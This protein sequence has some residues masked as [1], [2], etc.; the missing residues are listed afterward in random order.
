MTL[1]VAIIGLGTLAG[2]LFNIIMN[3]RVIYKVIGIVIT[4]ATGTFSCCVVLFPYNF[5]DSYT[6]LIIKLSLSAVLLVVIYISAR[7]IVNAVST[8][9][10]GKDTK[11]DKDKLKAEPVAE[12][13]SVA[14]F[15][16][17]NRVKDIITADKTVRSPAQKVS[18]NL[19]NY[20]PK[21]AAVKAT[22]EETHSAQSAAKQT[23]GQA[24]KDADEKILSQSKSLTESVG[25]AVKTG[26]DKPAD[27]ELVSAA[28][29][30][31]DDAKPAPGAMYEQSEQKVGADV[32]AGAETRASEP[33]LEKP[34]GS[35]VSETK[36]EA[37]GAEALDALI[38]KFVKDK[39]ADAELVSAAVLKSNDA[40]PALGAMYEQ[41]EQKAGADVKAGAETKASEP[42]LEEPAGSDVS[43]TKP[44]AQG[45][46]AVDVLID[47]FVKDKAAGSQG[48]AEYETEAKAEE[49]A[50]VAG[51][52][53][54]KPEETAAEVKAEEQIVLAGQ[55]E[56]KA[57]EAAAEAKAEDTAAVIEQTEAKPE[58]A[59]AEAK[60][61]E[62]AAVIEQT[63]AKLEEAAAEAKTEEQAV[64]AG[65][66]EAKPEEAAAEAKAEEQ[67]VIAEQAVS[68]AAPDRYAAIIIKARELIKEGKYVYAA[69]L[70]QMCSDRSEDEQQ[71]KQ[72]DILIIEC[73]ALSDKGGEARNKWVE[74]LNKQ[75]TLGED[76]KAN[77]KRVMSSL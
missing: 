63:E 71:R 75:Y 62:T 5:F 47:K 35:D 64:V 17:K 11:A 43:E 76:D 22:K 49:Q 25:A 2:I 4:L 51:Q 52:T 23:F 46:K 19:E 70:L 54:A 56:V 60:A 33:V 28:A 14:S 44:E 41:P 57:E 77:L 65:Q 61:E 7:M 67:I 40:K 29:L 13:I 31:P 9:K 45:A 16:L 30:K 10:G 53:E 18:V 74:F 20:S 55:A 59:V 58:E 68:A 27:A 36:P 8:I 38:N 37:Q 39:P 1:Y 66:T 34:A 48:L 21:Y 3:K 50:A 15:A 73:L 24:L 42:V 32:K 69:G 12:E 72:A 6:N 26:A